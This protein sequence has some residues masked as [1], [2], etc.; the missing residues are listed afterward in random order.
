VH[1][2]NLEIAPTTVALLSRTGRGRWT[3]ENEGFNIQKHHGYALQHKYAHVNWQ[4]AKNYYHC[5]QTGN[6]GVPPLWP[7]PPPPA[8]PTGPTALPDPLAL[9][10][11][12]DRLLR[13]SGAPHYP[14]KEVNLIQAP[15]FAYLSLLHASQS[16]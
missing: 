9:A 13:N 15:Q 12:G 2:T 5:L 6:D 4:A 7:S 3:I 11:P 16:Y 14:P 10:S 8:R 1:L